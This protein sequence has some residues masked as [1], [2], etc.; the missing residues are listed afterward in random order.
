MTEHTHEAVVKIIELI[1]VSPNSWSD[2]A[3]KGVERAAE[4]I[5]DIVGV[6]VVHS[7]AAVEAGR[8]TEYR[9][10]LKVAFLVHHAAA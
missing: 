6:D 2:A 7:T 1:G 10:D 9:V 4:T 5:D 3:R 8:I